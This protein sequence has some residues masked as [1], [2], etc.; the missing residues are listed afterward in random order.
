ML[1]FMNESLSSDYIKIP[2]PRQKLNDKP[3]TCQYQSH[4]NKHASNN[5]QISNYCNNS[6]RYDKRKN[7]HYSAPDEK[8]EF[9]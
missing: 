7:K 5:Q 6:L 3:I 8:N 2:C 9:L 1:H 4:Y